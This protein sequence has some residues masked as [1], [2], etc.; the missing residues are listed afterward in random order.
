MVKITKR[1][2][3]IGAVIIL[4]CLIS[5]ITGYHSYS[6]PELKLNTKTVNVEYGADVKEYL[7]NNIDTSI[8]EIKV[9]SMILNLLAIK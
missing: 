7:I 3:I 6:H 5:G 8:Y 4:I 2:K 1:T 9:L